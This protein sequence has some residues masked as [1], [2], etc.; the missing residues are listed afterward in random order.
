MLERRKLYLFPG[1]VASSPAPPEP[2]SETRH[3]PTRVEESLAPHYI[4]VGD[5]PAPQYIV[6]E[7]SPVPMSGVKD[8]P[9]VVLESPPEATGDRAGTTSPVP[10]SGTQDRPSLADDS[11]A[12]LKVKNL[13][14][15]G[16]NPVEGGSATLA[17]NLVSP[18]STNSPAEAPQPRSRSTDPTNYNRSG[19]TPLYSGGRNLTAAPP[20]EPS[21]SY[22]TSSVVLPGALHPARGRHPVLD[23]TIPGWG[24]GG[25]NILSVRG[26][27]HLLQRA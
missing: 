4:M 5:S 23:S 2:M 26:H 1:S 7:Q 15:G 19:V 13:S 9:C 17:K 21:W 18:P 14:L 12:V 25:G 24:F 11:L 8:H 3:Q 27:V 10:M 16:E 20:A 6:V 22:L